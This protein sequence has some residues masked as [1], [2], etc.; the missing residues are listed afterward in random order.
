MVFPSASFVR[1][2]EPYVVTT[3]DG[4]LFTG[5]IARETADALYLH[6]ADR[7]EIRVP[8]SAIVRQTS[9][10]RSNSVSCWR[11]RIAGP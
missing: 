1:G 4:R 11:L 5:V 7:S 10:S 6:T 3:A 9:S 8:R 2:Y